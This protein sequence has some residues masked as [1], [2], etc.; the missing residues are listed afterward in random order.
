M[1]LLDGRAKAAAIYPNKLIDAILDGLQIEQKK[2]IENVRE[3]ELLI[4]TSVESLHEFYDHEQWGCYMDDTS[5]KELDPKKVRE[6]RQKEMQT[7]KEM[8]VYEHVPRWQ[9]KL[10]TEG[11][12][13]GVRWVDVDKGY[14]VRS[15]LVAQEFAG[16]NDRDDL[17]A[18]TPPLSATK[19]ILSD[20]A[21][22][23]EGGPGR[24]RVMVLDVKRAFLYGDIEEI[25]YIELPPEDPMSQEG[26]V[27]RL[28]KAMYGTRAAPQVWQEVVKRTMRRLGFEP[29]VKTPC[30]YYHPDRDLRVCTHVD[31][32]LCGGEREH[33][34]WLKTELEKEFE[35]KSE[36]LGDGVDDAAVV[37]HGKRE[38]CNSIYLPTYQQR[39]SLWINLC[40]YMPT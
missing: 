33:L 38:Y 14:E 37:A 20:V 3:I 7:F 9:A 4:M 40:R 24:K 39:N 16:K 23:R 31:D 21:S 17:F 13:V 18:G 19:L 27:G 28:V 8:G 11:K 5:G 12:I 36:V 26:M 10:D 2:K 6:A 30:V 1:N 35:M 34:R 22:C 29:C 25:I 32:F 15:R